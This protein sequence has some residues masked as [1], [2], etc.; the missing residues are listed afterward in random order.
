M[1]KENASQIQNQR[2]FYPMATPEAVTKYFK[3]GVYKVA[4]SHARKDMVPQIDI[5]SPQ[6]IKDLDVA[7]QLL[8]SIEDRNP[9]FKNIDPTTDQ[10]KFD[11]ADETKARGMAVAEQATD[12]K[13]K[14][15][16]LKIVDWAVDEILDTVGKTVAKI[17]GKKV[18]LALSG[19]AFGA[20]ACSP[21]VIVP[22]VI[23]GGVTIQKG[24]AGES[25]IH[26]EVLIAT[27]DNPYPY[28][29]IEQSQHFQPDAIFADKALE[30][31]GVAKYNIDKIK[32]DF[33]I[34]VI[35]PATWNN[36]ANRPWS[37]I[38]INLLYKTVKNLPAAYLNNSRTPKQI[39]LFSL[40]SNDKNL[41]GG[42][43]AGY[44]NRQM[45]IGIP[46]DFN[47]LFPTKG[48]Y[49]EQFGSQEFL[50]EAFVKHEFTHAYTEAHP[51]VLEEWIVTMGWHWDG[52]NW[53]NENPSRLIQESNANVRPVEDIA[54]SASLLSNPI[55]LSPDRLSFFQSHPEFQG[56]ER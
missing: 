27:A 11:L 8:A 22:P 33:G 37:D 40:P 51:E 31:K 13:V 18:F 41:E 38:A 1:T 34:A 16:I 49:Q 19:L 44:G 24:T 52:K 15:K 36:E 20:A 3:D 43:T 30:Y 12:P 7:A 48:A 47:P 26:E 42:L 25:Y 17:G 29:E 6:D 56:L 55:F 10:G 35:S 9:N 28:A 14:A 50:L 23:P 21:N 39:L 54:V 45:T 46:A 32:E 2:E 4:I 53:T 5:I